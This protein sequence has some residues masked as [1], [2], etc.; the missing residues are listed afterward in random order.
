[1]LRFAAIALLLAAPGPAWATF[2]EID[3][4]AP[5]DALITRD[6][7]SGLDWLDVTEVAG[8]SYNDLLSG[9]GGW[10]D[11]GWRWATTGE[12]CGLLT[13]LGAAPSPCPGGRR[14]E[15][16]NAAELALA[17]LGYTDTWGDGP[18]GVGSDLLGKLPGRPHRP[19]AR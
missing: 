6:T 13:G 1:M 18:G 9:A 5:G 12:V 14:N 4:N 19:P 11:A 2:I 16:G 3:L 15:P 10:L 7:A 17:L 8:L